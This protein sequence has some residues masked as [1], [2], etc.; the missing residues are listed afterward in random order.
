M[1]EAYKDFNSVIWQIFDTCRCMTESGAF[2]TGRLFSWSINTGNLF[3]IGSEH[4]CEALQ[5]LEARDITSRW[6]R[7]GLQLKLSYGDLESIASNK[8]SVEDRAMAMLHQWLIS[9]RATKQ[10]LIDA[11]RVV[12]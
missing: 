4:I 7:I 2:D 3:S 1:A 6:R 11:V 9:D 8:A 5:Y 12:K 10:A